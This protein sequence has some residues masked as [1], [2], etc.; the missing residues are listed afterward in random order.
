VR[1]SERE[2]KNNEKMGARRTF[3]RRVG[4]RHRYGIWAQDLGASFVTEPQQAAAIT[5][6]SN[7]N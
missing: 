4:E 6:S 2:K 5:S 7:N 3:L 1:E